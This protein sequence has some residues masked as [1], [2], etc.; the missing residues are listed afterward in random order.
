MAA[1]SFLEGWEVPFMVGM[2]RLVVVAKAMLLLET[3]ESHA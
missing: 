1:G 2:D 3:N